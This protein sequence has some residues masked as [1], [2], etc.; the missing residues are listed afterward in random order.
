L[1]V[2]ASIVLIGLGNGRT[3]AAALPRAERL[4]ARRGEIADPPVHMLVVLAGYAA[5]MN[6]GAE[7]HALTGQALEC[8]PYPPP[9][10]LSIALIHSL[11][12]VER[13]DDLYRLSEA[14]LAAARR[15]G[16]VPDVVGILVLRAWASAECGALA[17]AEADARWALERA[18]GVARMQAVS[19]LVRVLVE[20]D[21]LDEAE[22]L[23]AELEDPRSSESGEVSRLLGVRGRL[24]AAQGRSQEALVDLV[25]CGE[26]NQRLGFAML[27]GGPWRAEAALAHAA[28]GNHDQAQRLASEQLAMA[29]E[30]GFARTLGVSLRASGLVAGGSD[31]LALLGEAVQTLETSGSPLELARALT[32]FG[33]ALRRSG[34]PGEAR[35]Q[36]ERGLDLAHHCGAR[37]IAGLA[38]AELIAAGAK[39]RRDAITGRDALTASELRVARLAGE[40]MSNREIAQ[41]LFT[42]PKTAKSHLNRI[43]RKLG[44][45]CRGELADALAGLRGAGDECLGG[46]AAG[47][48]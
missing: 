4:R 18:T 2:E 28:L 17:D 32:D 31:G 39:P 15:Q 29:R 22:G 47:I 9:R 3:A 42:T 46:S 14:L 12:V 48:S 44:I 10:E 13:Y 8:R 33:G 6:R 30:F 19:V 40:G 1:T 27:G 38:R 20:R 41:A 25:E 43:Y 24:R 23:L 11:I 35:A 26:R 7:A 45:T 34:R 16:A 5:R 36:L 37:R 21:A